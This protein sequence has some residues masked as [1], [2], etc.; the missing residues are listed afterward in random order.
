MSIFFIKVAGL[1]HKKNT[2]PE[3]FSSEFAQYFRTRFLRKTFGWWLLLL[4]TIHFLCCTELISKMLLSTLAMFWLSLNINRANT[5]SR[6]STAVPGSPRH[7]V[8]LL[9]IKQAIRPKYSWKSEAVDQQFYLKI[10][11]C[12][13]SKVSQEGICD[14]ASFFVKL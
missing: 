12:K 10:M 8:D 6:L 9:L 5:V 1:Q 4:N 13:T 2:P 3:M 14:E 11:F 7:L